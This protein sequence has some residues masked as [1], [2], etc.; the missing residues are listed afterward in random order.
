MAGVATFDCPHCK[1]RHV[2]F[3]AAFEW[4]P[5]EGGQRALFICG[6]CLEGV[7]REYHNHS[8]IMQLTGDISRYNVRLDR[9]WPE[10]LPGSAPSDTPAT[11][12]SYFEQGTSSLEAGNFDAAGMMFRKALESATKVLSPELAGKKLVQRIDELAKDAKLTPDLAGWAHEVRLG[13]N[14]A[15]HEDEP[16]TFEEAVDL[17]N[18]MENFLRYAFTL[19]SA[20]RRRSGKI[21]ESME[22]DP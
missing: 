3:T 18:F 21:D 13:G 4:R 5:Q 1:T 2:A 19:P 6:S 9:Q 15:A 7:I 11:V 12:G 16:F 20:V 10:P 22:A 8:S 14:D 17:R